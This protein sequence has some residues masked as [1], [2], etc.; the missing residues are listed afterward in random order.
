MSKII[1]NRDE[2]ELEAAFR[3]GFELG[4]NPTVG[5]FGKYDRSMFFDYLS[6]YYYQGS[7]KRCRCDEI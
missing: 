7:F 6:G 1:L 5:V 2:R 4:K 3:A